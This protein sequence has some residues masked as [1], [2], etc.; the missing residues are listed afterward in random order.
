[1]SGTYI[2]Y[3]MV[4]YLS[5]DRVRKTAIDELILFEQG[6]DTIM[7]SPLDS[8]PGGEVKFRIRKISPHPWIE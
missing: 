8:S 3:K 4:R 1:M 6:G 2:N 7:G 5:G